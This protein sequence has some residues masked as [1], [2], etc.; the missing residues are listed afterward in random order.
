MYQ[1]GGGRALTVELSMPA[2]LT[3]SL[4]GYGRVAGEG[5]MP[6]GSDRVGLSNSLVDVLLASS[7]EAAVVRT[8]STRL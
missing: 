6:H 3:G 7:R 2:F 1:P 5:F 8:S 4:Q